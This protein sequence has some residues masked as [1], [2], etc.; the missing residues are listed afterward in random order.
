LPVPRSRSPCWLL[1][2]CRYGRESERKRVECRHPP[3][4][5]APH[6]GAGDMRASGWDGHGH[7]NSSL[8]WIRFAPVPRVG[9][10]AMQTWYTPLFGAKP[11]LA[12]RPCPHRSMLFPSRPPP[13]ALLLRATTR[14]MDPRQPLPSAFCNCSCSRCWPCCSA[15][16]GITTCQPPMSMIATH[17]WSMAID[18]VADRFQ[19]GPSPIMG[20]TAQSLQQSTSRSRSRVDTQD[21]ATRWLAYLLSAD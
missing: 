9:A 11:C 6:P 15:A 1:L 21:C 12:S 8:D 19:T 13:T 5:P 20:F 2:L 7:S 16:P 4:C 18:D 3:P 14:H 10:A 17:E